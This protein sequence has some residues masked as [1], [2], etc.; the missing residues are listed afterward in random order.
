MKDTFAALC[1]TASLIFASALVELSNSASLLD[2]AVA[3][4]ATAFFAGLTLFF[5]KD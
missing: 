1:L 3:G 5:F 2:Y 4:A